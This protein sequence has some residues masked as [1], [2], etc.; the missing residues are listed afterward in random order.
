M[1]KEDRKKRS[2]LPN[3]KK[4]HDGFSIFYSLGHILFAD[5]KEIGISYGDPKNSLF[6]GW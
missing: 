6:I 4:Y 2:F 1:R 3:K 5:F